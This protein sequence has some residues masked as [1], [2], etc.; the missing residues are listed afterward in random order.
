L[1]DIG[2][3]VFFCVRTHRVSHGY[4][5][6]GDTGEDENVARRGSGGRDDEPMN[7]AMLIFALEQVVQNNLE[8]PRLKE[9]GDAFAGNG[10]KAEPK[11]AP[12]GT[13]NIQDAQAGLAVERLRT[14][15]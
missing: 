9:A 14:H 2:G 3:Q 11:L 15:E 7:P 6:D 13:Q 1:P 10:E 4:D 8:R 12:V 5:K